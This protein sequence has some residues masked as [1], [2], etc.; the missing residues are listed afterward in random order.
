[1]NT[2]LNYHALNKY[3]IPNTCNKFSAMPQYGKILYLSNAQLM[4]YNEAKLQDAIIIYDEID[5]CFQD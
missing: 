4:S 3:S 2:Y 1:M 5:R